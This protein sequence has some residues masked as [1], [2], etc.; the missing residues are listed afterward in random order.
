MTDLQQ[1]SELKRQLQLLKGNDGEYVVTA[2]G[3]VYGLPK[4]VEFI[5]QALIQAR[6]D[7]LKDLWTSGESKHADIRV[8]Y[9]RGLT[10][11]ERV[12]E[13]ESQK[14]DMGKQ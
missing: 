13:L 2:L 4:L 5:S 6:I 7:E 3:S 8:D 10:V 14:Q 11:W 9:D 12:A 1:D